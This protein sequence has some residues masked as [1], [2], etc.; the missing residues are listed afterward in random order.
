MG[1]KQ[2][3]DLRAEFEH[4]IIDVKNEQNK[5]HKEKINLIKRKMTLEKS[6]LENRFCEEQKTLKENLSSEKFNQKETQI[7]VLQ[8]QFSESQSENDKLKMTQKLFE[9]EKMELEIY[10]E[11]ISLQLTHGKK[12]FSECESEINKLKMT[13]EIL[14]NEKE[15]LRNYNQNVSTQL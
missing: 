3:V 9:K 6:K 11:N 5:M 14:E 7:N 1:E 15:N 8:K 2:I 12:Q 10:N 4:K 13:Q